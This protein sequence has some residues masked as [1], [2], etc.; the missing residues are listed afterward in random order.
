M[1]DL[2]SQNSELPTVKTGSTTDF[3]L[4]NSAMTQ[5]NN[6]ANVMA[7]G[8]ATVPQHLQGNP[9]DCLAVVMQ[10]AQWQM[11]PFAVAQKTHL[12]SGT[13][14]YEA[15]LVNAVISSSKAIQGR[16]KY[17]FIGEWS[18]VIGNFVT[19]TGR[20]NKPYQT[21]GW[22]QQDEQG[23]GVIV[24]AL[25]TGDDEPTELTLM[26]T[27][28]QTRNSTLWASDPRQQLAYLAVKRWA[29]LYTPDVILGVYTPDEFE[30]PQEVEINPVQKAKKSAVM[31]ALNKAPK[32]VKKVEKVVNEPICNTE[33]GELPILEQWRLTIKGCCELRELEEVAQN[34]STD[35]ELIP[36]DKEIL[37]QVYAA[38]K[39]ELDRC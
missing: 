23:L 17:Q 35:E 8:S 34:L 9:A 28:A 16:F 2:Q 13:L 33:T 26:L 5:M 6:L 20:N 19:K 27:Q 21:P 24:S 10:A 11:N 29:R 25:I 37:R 14:G 18:Q 12:I 36:Q 15:Q 31:D 30:Q 22:S 39:K 1:N 32:K 4:D 7:G 3:V 38:H